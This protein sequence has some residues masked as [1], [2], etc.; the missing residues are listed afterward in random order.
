MSLIIQQNG[1][2]AAV[3]SKIE[4]RLLAGL[5]PSDIIFVDMQMPGMD[6]IQV[7]DFLS[8]HAVKARV[9]PMSCNHAQVLETAERIAR[10]NGLSVAGSLKKPFRLNELRRILDESPS[11]LQ[12]QKGNQPPPREINID[13]IVA[14]LEQGEFDTYLQPIVDLLT[15]KAIGYEALAR[16]QSEKFN[17]VSPDRFIGLVAQNGL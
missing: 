4:S 16:W 10:R 14:G 13:D 11:T 15:R 1:F 17:F 6:G 5:G 2:E 3:S 7:L 9:V 12:G 8:R